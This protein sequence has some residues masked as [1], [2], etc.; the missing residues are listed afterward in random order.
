MLAAAIAV[1]AAACTGGS[2]PAGPST[3][4]GPA[5]G[6]RAGSQRPVS[7][8]GMPGCSAA[9]AAAP[10]L[11]RVPTT[12][13]PVPGVPFGVVVTASGRWAFVSFPV[14]GSVDVFRVG[15]QAVPAPPRQLVPAGQ[16]LGETLTRNGRYLLA[17][18]GRGGAGVI[19]VSRA[20]QGRAG[21]PLGTLSSP[22][23]IGAIE[24]TTSPDG[25]FAFVS[26]E[27]STA[28][29]VFNLQQA[30]TKGFGAED[31]AGTIPVG[32]A[33]VGLA[34][35]PDGRWLYATSEL[36]ASAQA[37][38]GGPGPGTLSVINLHRA[39]TD[40]AASV[41]ATVT[42]G[43]SPV[44]VVTSADGRVI[45]VT[46]RGSDRL[47]AFSASRLHTDPARALLASVEVGEAPVGLALVDRGSGS[48]W[49]IPTGSVPRA[50]QRAWPWS[51]SPRRWPVS[52]P[53]SV[54]CPRAASRGRW[55]W[56]RPAGRCW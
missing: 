25:R 19:S 45:W 37:H 20:E 4:P 52:Q 15:T 21:A 43:C 11:H 8:A 50:P 30:L 26:L 34:V 36:A 54:T 42:A 5:S 7:V 29:A 16:P 13:T 39:E 6:A 46:A 55:R 14:A 47:L 27:D 35:S 32:F 33:P 2:H 9:T 10:V 40:P 24:V 17:A 49:P 41:V 53:C 23:G 56:S 31:F 1:A 28:I 3:S 51:A 22:K 44:R 12:M 18:D 48:W 38:V